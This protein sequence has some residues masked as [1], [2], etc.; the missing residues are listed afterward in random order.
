MQALEGQLE[1]VTGVQSCSIAAPRRHV[2]IA[3]HMHK[4]PY[5]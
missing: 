5:M 1:A 2:E 3:I 4:H